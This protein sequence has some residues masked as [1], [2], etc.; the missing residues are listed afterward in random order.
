MIEKKMV[1]LANSVKH[2]ER[3]LAGRELC[4]DGTWGNWIRPVSARL[5]EGLNELERFYNGYFEPEVLDVIDIRL[6]RANPHSCQSENWL[7]SPNGGWKF[8]N[9]LKWAQAL[10]LKEVPSQLWR[11]G[12]STANGQ[13]DEMLELHART[14]TTSIAIIHIKNGWVQV[15]LGYGDK[16][17]VFINFHYNGVEY[18][19]SLTDSVL[20]KK[21]KAGPLGRVQFGESLMTISLAEP[22]AKFDGTMCQYKLIAAIIPKTGSMPDVI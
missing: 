2:G 9:S 13:H 10:V 4:A 12:L 15:F 8:L 5:G 1:L 16:K 18:K 6:I 11:N 19:F 7:V 14:F 20:E 22:F 3:C 17:K 21:Y